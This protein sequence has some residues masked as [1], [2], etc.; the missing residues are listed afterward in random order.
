M[1]EGIIVDGS[2]AQAGM[3]P[4]RPPRAATRPRLP[5]AGGDG[6]VHAP[7]GVR[8]F[9]APPRRRGWTLFT[10]DGRNPALGSPAQAGMDPSG[11]PTPPGGSWLPRAGG[12]GPAA[13][14]PQGVDGRAPPRRRGWTPTMASSKTPAKGS[15]AQAGMDPEGRIRNHPPTRLPR[16]GG[17]GPKLAPP[18]REAR[19]APPRRRGWTPHH[20]APLLELH[21]SPA[22]AGMDPRRPRS[23]TLPGGLPRAG[24]DGP[25]PRMRVLMP[26]AAPP[27]RRGWTPA[28]HGYPCRAIGSPAQA[29]MDPAPRSQSPGGPRLPRAGGDGPP[30]WRVAHVL[31]WAPPRRRGWTR[32]QP[33]RPRGATGSPAQAGMDPCPVT[34]LDGAVGLPRAGGD[35][36]KP[37]SRD[38]LR[39]KAPP[40]RR[41]WTRD[42]RGLPERRG[43]SPAQAGMDPRGPR[44]RPAGP[45]LPR[46]GG[47]G[48]ARRIRHATGAR[49]PPRRRGWTHARRDRHLRQRGSPAQAG[50]DPAA[51]VNASC[52]MG[53][54]RAGG[55]G[56]HRYPR[57]RATGRAPPRRRGWTPLDLRAHRLCPG[58][59]AQAGMDPRR[60]GEAPRGRRL[61]RAGGDGPPRAA[62]SARRTR[63][64]PRRRGWTRDGGTG[65]VPVGGSPAQAG[66]DPPPVTSSKRP[67]GLPRAGGDGPT[68]EPSYSATAAAPPRRRG[69][70]RALEG[71]LGLDAGSPAQAGMDPCSVPTAGRVSRLPRAGGDGPG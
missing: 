34:G 49:A 24:G 27:R 46:A 14:P 54:P 35:G 41:G 52:W 37:I 10:T 19:V 7:R 48:P 21:G 68:A 47:D 9:T 8:P 71:I 67:A 20:V 32:G 13:T 6:P 58:S 25:S 36:P 53:L 44:T 60:R 65:A 11:C 57:K 22:Q 1:T 43:G 63:A 4:H 38:V 70:T 55:D 51:A 56:P 33:Q 64:P 30:A 62:Y 28:P 66:M 50:M 23:I 40:R 26:P 29:G 45:G 59:P 16:A 69:W 5:R 17:D 12:D 39:A 2:P 42:R 18:F 61:P 31:A 3:D 15:P